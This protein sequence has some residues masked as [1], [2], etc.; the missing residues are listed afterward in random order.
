MERMKDKVVIVTGAGSGIGQACAELFAEEGATVVVESLK[1]SEAERVAAGIRERGYP[2][3]AMQGDVAIAAD[4]ERVVAETIR[5]FGRVDVLVSNAAIQLVV[6]SIE[7]VTEADWDRVMDVNL[8]GAFLLTRA[9]VPHMKR[10]G[11][12][13][14]LFT[15]SEM[16]F[17][18]DPAVP[19]YV[20]SKGGLHMFMKAIAVSLIKH[21]IRVNAFCPGET[22]TPLLQGEIDNA[23]DPAA[24]KAEYDAWA[25]IGRMATP[26]EQAHIALFLAS[27]ESSFVVGSTYLA[28]GGFT[29][30]I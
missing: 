7:F 28:D 8:K 29:A 13:I 19:V 16:G 6:E 30:S 2:A 1:A 14:I 3:V 17:V 22:D 24:R 21:N 5:E 12:G 18:A 15:G 23:P 11:G 4:V 9:V 26:R 20:A 25:P 27:D 10:Q